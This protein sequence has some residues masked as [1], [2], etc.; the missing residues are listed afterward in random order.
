MEGATEEQARAELVRKLLVKEQ[1]ITRLE[2][3]LA[4]KDHELLARSQVIFRGTSRIRNITPLGPYSRTMPR[5]LG[6]P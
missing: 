6:R 3:K 2:E 4:A 5:A 1:E